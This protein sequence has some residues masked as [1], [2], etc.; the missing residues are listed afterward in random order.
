MAIT[1]K[2][3]RE[4]KQLV[5]TGGEGGATTKNRSLPPA[6]AR[7]GIPAVNSSAK[8]ETDTRQAAGG[9][10]TPLFEGIQGDPTSLQRT[11]WGLSVI[12]GADGLFTFEY[13]AIMSITFLDASGK[14]IEFF[15]EDDPPP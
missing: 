1:S 3:V 4:L 11:F 9:I 7:A 8:Q 10:A 12:S 14:E 6:P 2:T 15:F 5:Q 13:K